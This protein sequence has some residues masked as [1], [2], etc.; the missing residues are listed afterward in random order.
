MKRDNRQSAVAIGSA[1]GDASPEASAIL[2]IGLPA[3]TTEPCGAAA[4]SPQY[5]TKVQ[6]GVL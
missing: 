6:G 1:T 4:A 3:T 5:S 2:A